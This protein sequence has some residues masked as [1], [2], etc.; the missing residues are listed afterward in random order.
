MTTPRNR[1]AAHRPPP[2]ARRSFTSGQRALLW[3]AGVL[4]T[5]AIISAI[6][7]VMADRE[8]RS[9]PPVE[10]TI[11]DTVVPA[12][13]PAPVTPSAWTGEYGDLTV[14]LTAMFPPYYGPYDSGMPR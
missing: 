6:L 12:P 7:I 13:T 11:T 10:Q 9:V 2:P 1:T 3:A 4:G 8:R 5:L 14:R